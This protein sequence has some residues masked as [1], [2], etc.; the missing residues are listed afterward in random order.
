MK[1]KLFILHFQ[2]P[3]KVIIH[4]LRFFLERRSWKKNSTT[5]IYRTRIA[6]PLQVRE[7]E[8][9]RNEGAAMGEKMI[10]VCI[11]ST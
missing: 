11:T 2:H 1:T 5:F 3:K 8:S 4:G 6:L 7:G 10:V 9:L